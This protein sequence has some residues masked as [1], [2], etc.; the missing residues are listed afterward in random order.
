MACKSAPNSVTVPNDEIK[1]IP[2]SEELTPS[3]A[4]PSQSTTAMSDFYQLQ[5]RLLGVTFVLTG[6]I[7]VAVWRAYSQNTA[8]NYL[9]G[10]I[11]GMVYLKLL[12]K[13]VERLNQPGQGLSKNRLVLFAGLIIVAAQLDQLNILPVFLGFLTYKAAIVFYTLQTTLIGDPK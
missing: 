11:V 2:D 13:D 3:V 10:A 1:S 8:L 12:A 4:S 7:F 6:I 5:N 9:L